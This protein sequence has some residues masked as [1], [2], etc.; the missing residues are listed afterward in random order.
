MNHSLGMTW[1]NTATYDFNLGDHAFNVL[2]GMESYRYSGTY[3]GGGQG[4]L[5]E[6]FD[7]WEHAWISNGTGSTIGENGVSVSGNPHDD[8]RSVSYFGR[9]GWNWQEK[10]FHGINPDLA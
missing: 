3:L 4:M 7:D 10:K 6:G 8:S 9:L 5:K 2:V 1:T